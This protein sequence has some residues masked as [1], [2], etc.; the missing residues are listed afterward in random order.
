MLRKIMLGFALVSMFMLTGCPHG[1]PDEAPK[2]AVGEYPELPKPNRPQLEVI[3]EAELAP[4][5]PE[6]RNKVLNT[7]NSLKMY[8]RELEVTID[9][10]N[11]FATQR[12]K[13]SRSWLD[14]KEGGDNG[15]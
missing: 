15:R 10:S 7:V 3:S 6:A 13:N 14:R 5:T 4:L 1:K 11:S 2:S 9:V 8:A 12:N